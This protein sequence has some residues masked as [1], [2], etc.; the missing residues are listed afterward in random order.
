M[1]INLF[2]HFHFRLHLLHRY[3]VILCSA[4]LHVIGCISKAIDRNVAVAADFDVVHWVGAMVCL[5]SD[6]S[7]Y[8]PSST[9]SPWS[10]A[11]RHTAISVLYL[12]ESAGIVVWVHQ[13]SSICDILSVT[14]FTQICFVFYINSLLGKYCIITQFGQIGNTYLKKIAWKPHSRFFIHFANIIN[15]T[16][17]MDF[18]ICRK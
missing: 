8:V 5:R 11:V 6:S 14:S 10:S 7:W 1:Q 9:E 15:I 17:C 12:S 3:C 16:Y 4:L 18:L 13:R 2:T